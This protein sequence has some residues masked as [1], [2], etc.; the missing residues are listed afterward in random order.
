MSFDNIAAG[1][2]E[3]FIQGGSDLIAIMKHLSTT[4]LEEQKMQQT[5]EIE[6]NKL[7]VEMEKARGINDLKNKQIET[8][9]KLGL[10]NA[11]IRQQNADTY[12]K[13]T[14]D[15]GEHFNRADTAAAEKVTN[16]RI[17]NQQRAD[18][19]TKR[20]NAAGNEPSPSIEGVGNEPTP[21]AGK[22]SKADLDNRKFQ[23]DIIKSEINALLKQAEHLNTIAYDRYSTSEE[24][25]SATQKLTEINLRVETL[26][27]Q[28]R[29][30]FTIPTTPTGDRGAGGGNPYDKFFR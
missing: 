22:I 14:E 16:D 28:L 21:N 15:L 4:E 12:A 20:V 5:K 27:E 2:S 11:A 25:K 9:E 10:I 26:R 19:Y 18:A 30:L 17:I 6:A 8:N 29:G 24:K 23:A 3:A 13:R 7:K 1:V